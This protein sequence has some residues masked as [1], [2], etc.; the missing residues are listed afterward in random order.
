MISQPSFPG[1]EKLLSITSEIS[2]NEQETSSLNEVSC[3]NCKSIYHYVRRHKPEKLKDL[4]TNLPE[5]YNRI[6]NIEAFLTDENNWVS[7]EMISVLFENVVGIFKDP[8]IPFHIGMETITARNLSLLQSFFLTTFSNPKRLIKRLNQINQQFNTTKIIETV[9]LSNSRAVI[10]LHWKNG[11]TLSKSFCLYNQGIYA[12]IPTLWGV[13]AQE[14]KETECYFSGANYCQYNITFQKRGFL[15]FNLKNQIKTRKAK[16]ILALEEIENDKILLKKKNEEVIKLNIELREKVDRLKAINEASRL[17]VSMV[18]TDEILKT[19]MNII[20]DVLRFDRALLMLIDKNGEYLEYIYS[21]GAN[22]EE[23]DRNLKDYRIPMTRTSNILI[24]TALKGR[25]LLIRD[26]ERAGLNPENLIIK[27]FKPDS[28]A[29]CPLITANGTIGV[30]AADRSISGKQVSYKELEHLSIFVNNIAATLHKAQQDEEIEKSYLNTV[31]ALVKAIEE[32]DQYTRGHSERVSRLARRIAENM[33]L[34]RDEIS[35]IGI[36]SLLHDVGKIG[37]PES[38]VKSPKRLTPAEY[39][40]IQTHP[41]K[42]AE[43]ISPIRRLNGHEYLIMSHHERYD[44]KGYPDGLKGDQI[45]I[46]AQIISI[47]DTFDAITS[48]RAYR[49]GLPMA[50]AARRIRDSRGKQFSPEVTDAFLTVYE[51]EIINDS[52]FME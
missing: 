41:S 33:E 52:S 16:L 8:S 10:R 37:I 22:Q 19:T 23:I 6:N 26:T 15:N 48:S 34:S 9:Y 7:S 20:V 36:G 4:F 13:P 3:S 43:I 32:K 35:F 39:K 24:R 27:N 45:P 12:A 31:K 42:G 50:E 17:L 47:A 2:A 40:I 46:G 29:F 14:V 28:I 49:K 18:D 44:G 25:P 21:T 1:T 38:I 30:L 5:P 51:N 11:R